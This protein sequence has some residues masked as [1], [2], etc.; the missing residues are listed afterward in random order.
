MEKFLNE[1]KTKKGQSATHTRIP[2]IGSNIYGGSYHI[3]STEL[4]AFHKLYFQ[5]VVIERNEDFLT[6]KQY[7]NGPIYIDFDFKYN[8]DI[9]SR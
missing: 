1:H 3:P 4:D 5:H 8:K 2:C 7:E 9:I 6:E